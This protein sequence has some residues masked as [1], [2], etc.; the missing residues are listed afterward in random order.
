MNKFNKTNRIKLIAHLTES[1]LSNLKTFLE[2][3]IYF[4]CSVLDDQP[5]QKLDEEFNLFRLNQVLNR[6]Y[7]F[8][9]L[10]SNFF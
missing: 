5:P 4:S 7:M 9:K 1:T 2:Y 8:K 3:Q 6:K 10:K